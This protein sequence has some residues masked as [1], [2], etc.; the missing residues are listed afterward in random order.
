MEQPGFTGA[1]LCIFSATER[2][3]VGEHRMYME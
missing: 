3:I 2:V 1:V